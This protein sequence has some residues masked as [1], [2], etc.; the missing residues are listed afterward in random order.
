MAGVRFWNIP[1]FQY[2]TIA[3][4][5]RKSVATLFPAKLKGRQVKPTHAG[6]ESTRRTLPPIPAPRVDSP[7]RCF[8]RRP[9][10]RLRRKEGNCK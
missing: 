6:G 2:D 4:G 1:M 5:S 9:S 7:R 8:A 3:G 10:L